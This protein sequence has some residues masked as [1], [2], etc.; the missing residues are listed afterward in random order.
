MAK[1]H[2]DIEK[3]EIDIVQLNATLAG[4]DE[5]FQWDATKEGGTF[6]MN[7]YQKLASIKQ[8]HRERQESSQTKESSIATQLRK[9]AQELDPI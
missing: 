6:W 4:L 1:K 7:V 9:L 5:A 3:L 2:I 8:L